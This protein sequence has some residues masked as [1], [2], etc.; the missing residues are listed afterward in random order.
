MSRNLDMESRPAGALDTRAPWASYSVVVSSLGASYHHAEGETGGRAFP[1]ACRRT[2]AGIPD[3][4]SCF[5]NSR[6]AEQHQSND[7]NHRVLA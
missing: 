6:S 1:T 5:K 2:S 3:L 7:V 4:C